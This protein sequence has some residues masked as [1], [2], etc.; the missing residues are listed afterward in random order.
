M[1]IREGTQRRLDRFFMTAE[2]IVLER[3]TSARCKSRPRAVGRPAIAYSL[4]TG[5][6]KHDA[7]LSERETERMKRAGTPNGI[8]ARTVGAVQTSGSCCYEAMSRREKF[9]KSSATRITRL[10]DMLIQLIRRDL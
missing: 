6:A 4:V 7:W 2:K 5:R 3:L 9:P 10:A 1:A 8:S